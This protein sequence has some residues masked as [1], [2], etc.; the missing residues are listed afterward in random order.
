LTRRAIALCAAVAAVAAVPCTALAQ[1]A[2]ADK[3]KPGFSR[4]FRLKPFTPPD[5]LLARELAPAMKETVAFNTPTALGAGYTFFG[6]FI[7]HDLTLDQTPLPGAKIELPT[8]VN[9]RTPYFDLDSVYGG[10]P[11]KSPALYDGSRFRL[12]PDGRDVPRRPDGTAIIADARNDE[13]AIISQLHMVFLRLHNSFIDKGMSFAQAHRQVLVRYQKAVLTDFLPAMVGATVT[14]QALMDPTPLWTPNENVDLPVE[15]TVAAYRFGHSMVR[16]AYRMPESEEGV[17]VPFSQVFDGTPND[18][19]G[20]RPVPPDKVVYWPNFLQFPDEPAPVNV[21]RR[22]D[23][24]LTDDLFQ[25]PFP[26]AITGGPSS[27]AERNLIRGKRYGLP[28]GQK[29]ARRLGLRPLTNRQLGIPAT[30]GGGA[31]LWFYVLGEANSRTGGATLG[32]VGGT[33]V[34]ATFVGLLRDDPKSIL[35]KNRGKV[36]FGDFSIA[37]LIEAAGADDF[38]NVE[39]FAARH[40]E[41]VDRD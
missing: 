29:V 2:P 19:T 34:A 35:Q 36:I 9:G 38:N 18:L 8:L 14:S 33:I 41:R 40:P 11:A 15:F 24:L 25:L 10:G 30:F 21:H 27:L 26:S 32:K 17:S 16:T 13:N 12:S 31:P 37:Q 3:D 1:G 5:I 39:E 20:G 28:N 4:M 22:I 23:P 7:D 6:Q